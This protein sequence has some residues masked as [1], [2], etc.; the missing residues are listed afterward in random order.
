VSTTGVNKYGTA[1]D[2]TSESESEQKTT[3]RPS[4]GEL[5][6]AAEREELLLSVSD[7]S[8]PNDGDGGSGSA[9]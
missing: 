7:L 9:S 3:D 8:S 2:A 4:T 5:D 1:N 6:P